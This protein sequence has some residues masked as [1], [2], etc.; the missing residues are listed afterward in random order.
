[1]AI[2]RTHQERRHK[3]V[4]HDA[5][6]AVPKHMT[7]DAHLKIVCQT[8]RRKNKKQHWVGCEY[9]HFDGNGSQLIVQCTVGACREQ[10]NICINASNG[11]PAQSTYTFVLTV[12][13]IEHHDV[14]SGWIIADA[15]PDKGPHEWTKEALITLE[16][17]TE[18]YMVKV[19]AEIHCESNNYCLVCFHDVCNY[20]KGRRSGTAGTL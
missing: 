15:F 7:H 10:C 19:I 18:A 14:V 16:K 11:K 4:H 17:I 5:A 3:L 13:K 6:N 2:L 9:I 12:S 8:R 20:G 1:M